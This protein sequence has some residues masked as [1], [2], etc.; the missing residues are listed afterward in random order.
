MLVLK[1]HAAHACRIYTERAR[2][3]AAY[4]LVLYR[5]NHSLEWAA[6]G[7]FVGIHVRRAA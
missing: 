5:Y 1:Y 7:P 4:D 2:T 3:N 6:R